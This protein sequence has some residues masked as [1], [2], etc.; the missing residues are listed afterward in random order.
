MTRDDDR[1]FMAIALRLAARGLGNVWPNPA[2]GCVV[3]KGGRI[4]GRGWTREGGRPHAET[5]ALRRAGAAAFSAT[6]YVTFE[7]CAHYGKTPPCTMALLHAGIRRVVAATED[8]DP[9]VDGQGLAQLRQAGVEV[10]C[11]LLRAEAEA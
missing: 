9:R 2:V 6:A 5:E 8:P 11:G 4:V 10:E 7:P 1:R 3:A